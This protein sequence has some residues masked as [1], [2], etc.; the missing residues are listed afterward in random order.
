[1]S[2]VVARAAQAR[3]GTRW[4]VLGGLCTSAALLLGAGAAGGLL[5][6]GHGATPA[7]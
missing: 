1:M 7:S 2:M 3:Q 4:L 5:A 6:G